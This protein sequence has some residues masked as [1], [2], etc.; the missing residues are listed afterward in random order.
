MQVRKLLRIIIIL[1]KYEIILLKSVVDDF[2]GDLFFFDGFPDFNF[3][4]DKN[5]RYKKVFFRQWR[6]DATASDG[7]WHITH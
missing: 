5:W 6:N 7:G 1:W 3:R 4:P 2:L